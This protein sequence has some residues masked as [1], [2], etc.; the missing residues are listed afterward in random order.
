MLEFS[1]G[2][3]PIVTR[4]VDGRTTRYDTVAEEFRL[5]RL[6]WTEATAGDL[7]PLPNRG[8]ILLCTEG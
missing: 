2:P 1:A 6:D 8:R 5:C 4:H 3:P 7:V